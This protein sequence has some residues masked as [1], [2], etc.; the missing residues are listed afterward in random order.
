[1]HKII[2]GLMATSLLAGALTASGAA[3]A[4]GADPLA[5]LSWLAGVWQGKFMGADV[6]DSYEPM[7]NGEMLSVMSMARNGKVV[8]YEM[9]RIY[10]KNGKAYF[11]ELAWGPNLSPAP[12]VPLR[13]LVTGDAHHA[14][15]GTLKFEKTGREGAVVWLTRPDKNGKPV[16]TRID[17]RRVSIFAKP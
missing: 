5:A 15:F 6:E 17:Y 13:M 2:K 11:Q 8:R 10:E 14:D 7:H 1:M 3:Q 12:K 9:R 4:Q 16:T